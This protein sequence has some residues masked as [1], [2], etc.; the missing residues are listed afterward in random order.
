MAPYAALERMGSMRDLVSGRSRISVTELTR[1]KEWRERLPESGV[2]EITDRGDTA[3][4][5]VSDDDMAAIVESY[6]YLE[7]QLEQTQIAAMFSTRSDARPQSGDELATSV[8]NAFDARKS[9]LRSV[10]D[11]C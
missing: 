6:A 11:G 7:E 4:W 3:G 10:V 8:A 5:L 2:I 1:G 9:A